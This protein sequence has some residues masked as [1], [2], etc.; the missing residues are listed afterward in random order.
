MAPAQDRI[1]PGVALMLVFC[2]TA[3]L[4][5]ISAKAAAAT[6]PPGQIAL[7]RFA[8][9]ALFMA[10]LALTVRPRA[11]PGGR[12]LGVSALRAG[13][14]LVSSVTFF[15]AVAVMPVAD[16]L[17]IAFV[18]SF[19]LLLLGWMFLG[20]RVGPWRL[21]ATAAGFLGALL[22]IRPS[23]ALFGPVALLPLATALSFAL[24]LLLTRRQSRGLHPI[25]MQVQTALLGTLLCL[26]LLAAGQILDIAALGLRMPSGSAWAWL[27]AVGVAATLSHL[28][29]TWALR[30]APA[31]TLAPLHYLELVAAVGFGYLVFGDFPAAATWAGIA[32]IVGSG[33]VIIHRERRAAARARR[34]PPAAPDAARAPASAAR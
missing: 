5:D 21:A 12:T 11:R 17:A 24:Y 32:V 33:L 3:P 1:L 2:V 15:A 13:L 6:L 23:L 9:Q 20:E 7:A 19:L 34:S 28:A 14:L 16:A 30:F 29:I 4:I 31:A 27:L 18:D 22:V 10:P 26:P 25:A 8:L